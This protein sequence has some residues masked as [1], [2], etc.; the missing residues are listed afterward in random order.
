MHSQISNP[1]PSHF[2]THSSYNFYEIEA[3]PYGQ[4]I[5][6]Y[7]PGLNLTGQARSESLLKPLASNSSHTIGGMSYE[8][9]SHYSACTPAWRIYQTAGRGAEGG[10]SASWNAKM[11]EQT[12]R[13]T[14]TTKV[15][16]D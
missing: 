12:A 2:H 1:P 9:R 7:L 10:H 14:T 15:D 6:M 4:I 16:P 5:S 8:P 13:A 3:D 11:T